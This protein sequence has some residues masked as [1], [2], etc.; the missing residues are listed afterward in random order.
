MESV[1]LLF[2]TKKAV[3]TNSFTTPHAIKNQTSISLSEEQK[4]KDVEE[5]EGREWRVGGLKY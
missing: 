1:R 5:I 3:M 2:F 4:R